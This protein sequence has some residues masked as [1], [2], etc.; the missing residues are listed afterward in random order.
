MDNVL[1]WGDDEPAVR[2]CAEK[3]H[4]DLLGLVRDFRPDGSGWSV[5][6]AAP[7]VLAKLRGTYRWHVVVKCPPGGDLSGLMLPYFRSRKAQRG[8]NVAVDVDPVD[9][10]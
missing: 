6:P 5:L 2:A 4:G 7:C 8:V 9:L 1:S 3:L 10:L